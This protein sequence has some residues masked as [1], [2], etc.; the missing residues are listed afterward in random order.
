MHTAHLPEQLL[1]TLPPA[2]ASK[3]DSP[4]GHR[5]IAPSQPTASD[6]HVR[7]QPP[8]LS[9]VVVA[10]QLPSLLQSA[11]PAANAS[12]LLCWARVSRLLISS[13]VRDG[14]QGQQAGGAGVSPAQLK[15]MQCACLSCKLHRSSRRLVRRTLPWEGTAG[16]CTGW[17]E[18]ALS[19]WSRQGA[20]P[21]GEVWR[22]DALPKAL[23]DMPWHQ[24]CT[25]VAAPASHRACKVAKV[26]IRDEGIVA[27]GA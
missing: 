11:K 10:M 8:Q 5:H 7:P 26:I 14:P 19:T 1:C 4:S 17:K 25:A 15:A 9:V 3:R 27:H 16:R 23:A 13:R 12:S 21:L 22:K 2:R 24:A 18:V 20:S 6:G